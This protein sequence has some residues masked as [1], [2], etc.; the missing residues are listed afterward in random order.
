VLTIA[1]GEVETF[2]RMQAELFASNA[3]VL[4][5][6]S[7][8]AEGTDR[9][10]AEEALALAYELCCPMPFVQAEF[11]KDFEPGSALESD[12]LQRFRGLLARAEQGSLLSRFEMDGDRAAPSEAYGACGHVVINQ[13]DLLVVVWDGQRL[14]KRGGTEETLDEARRKGV[15]IVWVDAKSPHSW[16][17][18]TATSHP[19]LA[20]T[21]SCL[22][23]APG[24]H[25]QELR[26]TIWQALEV[27]RARVPVHARAG[28]AP[29][30]TT[31]DEYY[32]ERQPRVNYAPLWKAFRD[33]LGDGSWPRPEFKVT[34]FETSVEQDWPPDRVSAH[35]CL[36]DWLRPFYAWSDKLAVNYSDIY[37]SAFV[38]AY[39]LAGLAVGMALL[40]L[41][42]GWNIF[43]PHLDETIFVSVELVLILA[44]LVIVWRGRR[45]KWHERW[46]DY[47]LAAELIRHLRLGAG[48]GSARAFPQVPAQWASYGDPASTWMAWYVRAVERD[49]GL[50]SVTLNVA[51]VRASASDLAKVIDGQLNYHRTNADRCHR[52]E[53][54]LHN[55]G[56]AFL[57]VTVVAC[58]VHLALGFR[59]VLASSPWMF[60]SV[61][62]LAGFLPAMGAAVAGISNQGEFRRVGKRSDAMWERLRD[63]KKTAD[64]LMERLEPTQQATFLPRASGEVADIAFL[65]AQLMVTEVLDWRVVFLDQ[66]LKPS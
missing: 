18:L 38:L 10:F 61:V 58:A 12:S 62:F 9:L 14:G 8:L 63:L 35:A 30:A 37:R 24:D 60:G 45:R 51:H 53:G 41:A 55:L 16:E 22:T 44:I 17:I 23:P 54:R 29:P 6:I 57:A 25:T 43:E 52:I 47:R 11:E 39:T 33:L 65:A 4:R 26:D 56:L 1:K 59:V 5:A 34:D 42:L 28:S 20:P 13:S 48:L 7:P 19:R 36:I 49:L 31:I 46:I 21:V 3:A 64:A 66:P 50:P 32:G 15:P 2:G 40:P 27:P